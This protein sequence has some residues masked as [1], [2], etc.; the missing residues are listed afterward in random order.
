MSNK[1]LTN[2]MSI[3]KMMNHGKNH[4][5]FELYCSAHGN[6]GSSFVCA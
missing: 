5:D 4:P 6:I 3:L 1:G 2:Q